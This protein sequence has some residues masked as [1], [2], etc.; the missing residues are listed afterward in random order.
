MATEVEIAK[1]ALSHLGE[2]YDLTALTDSTPEAEQINLVFDHTRDMLLR[3]HPWKFAQKY[4]KPS[5]TLPGNVPANWQYMFDYPFDCLR[6]IQ[7]VNPLGRDLDP[8]N[9]DIGTNEVDQKVILCDVEEPEFQYTYQVTDTEVFDIFFVEALALR[10]AARVSM[11]LTGD[12]R[13][14]AELERKA[15]VA[16]GKAMSQDGNEGVAPSISKGPDWI[17]ARA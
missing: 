16:V 10:L 7:L 11:S 5:T 12:A 14:S 4:H 2:R 17:R 6:M 1:L 8:I 3:E 13:F 9:F 15:D